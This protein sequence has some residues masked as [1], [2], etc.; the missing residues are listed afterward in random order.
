MI[1]I[2]VDRQLFLPIKQT[3]H[4]TYEIIFKYLLEIAKL[5]L[6]YQYSRIQY[7]VEDNGNVEPEIG[8]HTFKIC[9]LVSISTLGIS[10][11][12]NFQCSC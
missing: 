6:Y 5:A 3:R 2:P 9:T 8:Y 7:P 11:Q 1:T 10:F 12:H 4:S